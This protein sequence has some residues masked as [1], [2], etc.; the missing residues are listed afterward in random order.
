MR[1]LFTTTPGRGHYQA[2]LPIAHALRAAGHEVTWAAPPSASAH[3]RQKGFGAADAGIDRLPFS[4]WDD[5]PPEIAALPLPERPDFL[6]AVVFGPRRVAPMLK[7]LLPVVEAQDPQLLVCDQAELAG[8]IAAARAGVPNV[9]HAFGRLLPAA[10]VARGGEAM[11]ELWRTHGLEPR[12]YAG[13]YDHLYLDIYPP[14]LQAADIDHVGA[15]QLLRPAESVVRSEAADPLVY[16][17]FG[18]VFN[19]DLE[20]FATA[21]EAAR[22]LPV[23]VVVTLGPGNDPSA[24]G[25]QPDNVTVADFIPQAQLLPECAAVVSHAGSGT[26]LAAL[27]AGVPQ[28]LLPQAADQFLNAQAGVDGGVALTLRPGE[29]TVASVRNALTRVIDDARMREA[30]GRGAAEIAAMPGPDAVA[31][32]LAQRFG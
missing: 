30:A 8:P 26:F 28:L 15:I 18:T 13:T 20:L 22:E 32:E 14:S 16:I 2:M 4:P 1:V 25:A 5:P 9:T 12:P 6:F 27:A 19:E 3:L 21:V 23:R 7:D 10:R 31:D 11:A 29:V 17:T 24:L